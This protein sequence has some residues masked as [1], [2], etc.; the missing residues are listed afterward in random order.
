MK[1]IILPNQHFYLVFKYLVD[2]SNWKL[3]CEV[4]CGS[5]ET[6]WRKLIQRL[7]F[8]ALWQSSSG[9]NER[10]VLYGSFKKELRNKFGMKQSCHRENDFK[11]NKD[12][13][14][15]KWPAVVWTLKEANLIML[16]LAFGMQEYTKY[17]YTSV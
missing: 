11:N 16:A 2:K 8:V 3:V 14:Q 4:D 15:T 6:M 7:H 13:V 10:Q 5:N 1:E 17:K 12:V 9:R